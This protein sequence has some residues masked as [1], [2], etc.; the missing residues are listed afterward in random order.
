MVI[1]SKDA[2]MRPQAM[3]GKSAESYL[4]A[5]TALDITN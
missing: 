4:A 1:V 5:A 3:F 2:D